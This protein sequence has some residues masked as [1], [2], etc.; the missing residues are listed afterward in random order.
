[1]QTHN[2]A[3]TRK[4]FAT[5]YSDHR[6]ALTCMLFK[7]CY[8]KLERG[9]L[10]RKEEVNHLIPVFPLW[11]RTCRWVD[12]PSDRSTRIPASGP[13][14]DRQA[15]KRRKL[16]C[17]SHHQQVVQMQSKACSC[18]IIAVSTREHN[19]CS[20]Q[21]EYA[22]FYFALTFR[23]SGNGLWATGLGS[24]SKASLVDSLAHAWLCSGNK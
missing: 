3:F 10:W 17:I 1:M 16:S 20:F 6:E 19:G 22:T 14:T 21:P 23:L 7:R 18:P 5:H 12:A 24:I 11:P 2:T 15:A 13:K 9:C 8:R 4:H